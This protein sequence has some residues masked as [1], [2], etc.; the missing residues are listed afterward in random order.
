MLA[1]LTHSFNFIL[2]QMC[3]CCSG[4]SEGQKV[5]LSEDVRNDIRHDRSV[6]SFPAELAGKRRSVCKSGRL[7]V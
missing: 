3:S 7:A 2:L 5:D 4:K 6:L 1:W